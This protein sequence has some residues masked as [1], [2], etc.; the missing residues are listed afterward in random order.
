MLASV[1]FD[2]HPLAVDTLNLQAGGIIEQIKTDRYLVDHCVKHFH[3][4]E[5]NIE[6][7]KDLLITP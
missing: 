7:R 1:G 2:S 3:V 5:S 6:S 4:L